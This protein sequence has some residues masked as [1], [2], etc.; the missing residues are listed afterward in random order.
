[1][2]DRWRLYR[3]WV[4]DVRERCRREMTYFLFDF[5]RGVNELKQQTGQLDLSILRGANVIGMTTT[6]K[7][8]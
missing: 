8:G 3:R 2:E 4:K 6:G 1:M 7:Y 5:E